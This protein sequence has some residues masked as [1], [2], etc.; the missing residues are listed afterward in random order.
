[1]NV[2]NEMTNKK[3]IEEMEWNVTHERNNRFDDGK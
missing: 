3:N 1:M 2:M